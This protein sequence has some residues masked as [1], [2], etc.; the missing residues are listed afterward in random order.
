MLELTSIDNMDET[1]LRFDFQAVRHLTS[2]VSNQCRQ[3]TGKEKFLYSVVL[4]AMTDCS[5]RFTLSP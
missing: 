4:A 3:I 2:V 1:P 5:T